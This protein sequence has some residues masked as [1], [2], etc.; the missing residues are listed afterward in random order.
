MT[1]FDSSILDIVGLDEDIVDILLKQ[2]RMKIH[3]SNERRRVKIL[4][5]KFEEIRVLLGMQK[6]DSKVKILRRLLF[7]LDDTRIR[8]SVVAKT[9]AFD[10]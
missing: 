6:N 5:D 8:P 9:T 3:N 1:D 4:N 2:E 7:L 10:K